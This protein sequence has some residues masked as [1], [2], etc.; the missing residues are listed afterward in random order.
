M[1]YDGDILLCLPQCDPLVPACDEGFACV[2]SYA[3]ALT[4]VFVC[5]PEA[6]VA[7]RSLYA[8]ACDE[9]IGCGRLALHRPGPR[10]GCAG[11]CCTMP[12]DPLVANTCSDAATGQVCIVHDATPALGHCGFR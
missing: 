3:D 10:A 12:C 4:D 11:D 6:L 7:D 1:G 9:I 8:D 2:E 5:L